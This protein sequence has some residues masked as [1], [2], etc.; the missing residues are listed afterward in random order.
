[1]NESLPSPIQ[2]A[3][4]SRREGLVYYHRPLP[5][6]RAQLQAAWLFFFL[7]LRRQRFSARFQIQGDDEPTTWKA[8]LARFFKERHPRVDILLDL[9]F[10]PLG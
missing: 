6:S 4:R 2:S 9:V 8:G 5:W 3:L 1:M 7:S 10:G